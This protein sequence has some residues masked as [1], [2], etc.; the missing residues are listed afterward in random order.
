MAP[1]A[2]TALLCSQ[3]THAGSFAEQWA[4]Y[5]ERRTTYPVLGGSRPMFPGSGQVPGTST[6][7]GLPA[8]DRPPV[9][10]GRAG[11]PLLLVAHRDEVVTPLPWARAMRART[12][13]S[14]LVVADGE[15][16]TVTG[17]A[18]AGRVTAF[19]TRPE[20]TPAREA[21]CEP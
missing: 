17:G 20:E 14:L 19:F 5:G 3:V 18:C 6:C 2:G 1:F 11:G 8:P 7:A 21:V 10:P 12:G 4:A 16:A 9:E 15:H 13:G